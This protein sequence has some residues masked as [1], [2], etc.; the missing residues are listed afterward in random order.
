[1]VLLQRVKLLHSF[2]INWTNPPTPR[3]LDNAEDL[4]TRLLQQKY[5]SD[6]I[7]NLT[8]NKSQITTDRHLRTLCLFLDHQQILRVGG[9]LRNANLSYHI[10][11]P[12]LLPG[13]DAI[14]SSMILH[15]HQLL[16][17]AGFRTT[18]NH[19]L[20]S[21]ME[22]RQAQDKIL[23]DIQLEKINWHFNPPRAPH[24][25]GV[26]EACVKL[27]KTYLK[28]IVDQDTYNFEEFETILIFTEALVNSRPLTPMSTDP[29]DLEA[30]TPA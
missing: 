15:Y 4:L 12:A 21:L 3:E 5:F 17:H 8:D 27:V 24:Q 18:Y 29:H 6:V 13:S 1:M 9:R 2:R 16:A 19:I 11:H 22:L 23:P 26:W 20:E 10:K 28:K 30:L 25:G 7:Q 14:V